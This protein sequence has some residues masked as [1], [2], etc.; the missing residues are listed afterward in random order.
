MGVD[1]GN[2]L[3][4]RRSKPCGLR[5]RASSCTLLYAGAG[6]RSTIA[7][8]PSATNRAALGT[9][10]ACCGASR[11][12]SPPSP[13]AHGLRRVRGA[14]YRMG[15]PIVHYVRRGGRG[16]A[17]IGLALRVTRRLREPPGGP[18]RPTYSHPPAAN[19]A[20]ARV[21]ALSQDRLSAE[22]RESGLFWSPS[23]L[24]VPPRRR[25]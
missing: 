7:A 2:T 22:S 10:D 18:S 3:L 24:S 9:C 20:E 1:R 19:A 8:S 23:R 12:P 5:A 11:E 6:I 21:S 4:N 13:P 16:R 25:T 17:A 14:W 15:C